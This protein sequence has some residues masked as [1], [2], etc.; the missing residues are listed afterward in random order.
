MSNGSAIRLSTFGPVRLKGA[1]DS[2]RQMPVAILSES[3]ARRCCGFDCVY[4]APAAARTCLVRLEMSTG[5][6]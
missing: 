5:H 2:N 6:F 1:S 3:D 4:H